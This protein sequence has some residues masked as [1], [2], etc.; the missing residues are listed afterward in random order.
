[1]IDDPGY[2]ELVM[3]L[4]LNLAYVSF[5]NFISEYE[6]EIDLVDEN[7]LLKV[8]DKDGNAVKSLFCH[9]GANHFL[10][11]FLYTDADMDTY[12]R[13]YHLQVYIQSVRVDE[14]YFGNKYIGDSAL[15]LQIMVRD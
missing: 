12:E 5:P 13:Y 7:I 6:M 2:F 1:M 11:S 4:N 14:N 9:E 10:D 15:T 8:R 3:G